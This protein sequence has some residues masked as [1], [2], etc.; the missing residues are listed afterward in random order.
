MIQVPA[1][2]FMSLQRALQQVADPYILCLCHWLCCGVFRVYPAVYS[3][4]AIVNQ[5]PPW[6]AVAAFTLSLH[7]AASEA[8][9]VWLSNGGVMARFSDGFETVFVS[10]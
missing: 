4:A 3:A 10:E 7:W 6:V 9:V 8:D 5:S 1:R 2:Q